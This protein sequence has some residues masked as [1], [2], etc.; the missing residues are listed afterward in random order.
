MPRTR[1]GARRH[2]SQQDLR[3]IQFAPITLVGADDILVR[4]W[5]QTGQPEYLVVGATT[6]FEIVVSDHVPGAPCAGCVHP[7]ATEAP[8]VIPTVSFVSFWAGYLSAVRIL[9]H[10]AGYSFERDRQLTVAF[11]LQLNGSSTGPAS[12]RPDCPVGHGA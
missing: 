11:P 8:A 4:H 1:R 3:S 5:V 12:L 6:H 10:A 7:R 2:V 9:E